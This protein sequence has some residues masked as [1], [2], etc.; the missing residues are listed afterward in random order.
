MD[1]GRRAEGPRRPIVTSRR[2]GRFAEHLERLT[3]G[4]SQ[5][6][7]RPVICATG[8]ILPVEIAAGAEDH[9]DG[10]PCRRYG[11]EV[12]HVLDDLRMAILTGSG[13]A[14]RLVH[15]A[16]TLRAKQRH[17]DDPRLRSIVEEI[18][19]R[20]EVEIAKLTRAC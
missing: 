17:A 5:A 19:L 18:E 9:G 3:T 11:E 12:L 8:S 13:R 15:L 20:A 6:I 10:D 7:E 4:V 2:H 16:K 1:S 14:E